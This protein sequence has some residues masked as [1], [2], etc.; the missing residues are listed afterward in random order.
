MEQHTLG[1]R[2]RRERQN[3]HLTQEQLAEKL[4]VSSAYIGFVERGERN[5]TLNKLSLLADI[6]GVSIDYLLSDDTGSSPSANEKQMLS[7]FASASREDQE[8]ILDL[9]RTVLRRSG[10][11]Q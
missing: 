2:I 7:L 6:L 9:M 11:K 10:K 3:L 5:L 1:Q 4:N 8:L